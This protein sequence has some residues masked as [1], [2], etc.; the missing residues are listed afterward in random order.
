MRI[1]IIALL[2]MSLFDILAVGAQEDYETLLSESKVWTMMI[3]PSVNSEVYGDL[4]Y[5]NETKLVGDTVINGIN[6]KQKYERQCKQGEE[7]PAEWSATKEFLGQDGSKVY[8]FSSF[9]NKMILDTDISLQVGDKLGCYDLSF[10]RDLLFNYMVTVV[11]DTVLDCSTDKVRRKC[12]YVYVENR[13]PN[14]PLFTDVWIEGVGSQ[15]YGISGVWRTMT[16][17]AYVNMI[18]CTEG[19]AVI[20]QKDLPLNLQDMSSCRIENKTIFDLQGRHLLKMPL[21][22]VYIQNGKKRIVR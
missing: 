12:V 6:F 4:C 18:K 3:K 15:N 9:T 14:H 21:K 22:G 8:L 7:M 20:Y 19:D 11:S 2:L 13:P 17:G 16:V 10:Y 1:K 5:I